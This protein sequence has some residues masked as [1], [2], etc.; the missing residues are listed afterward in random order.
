M[1]KMKVLFVCSGNARFGITPN[2]KNQGES[3]RNNGVQLDY[4]PIKGKGIKGY[5]KNIPKLRNHLKSNKYDLIHAHYGFCGIVSQFARNKEKLI[6]TFMGDDLLGSNKSDGSYT[7]ISKVITN[8]NKYYARYKLDLSI[9]QSKSMQRVLIRRT[10]YCCIPNGVDF[11]VFYPLDQ[12]HSREKLNINRDDKIILFVSDPKRKE[13]NVSLAK[14]A[15]KLINSCR[16]KL[17]VVYSISHKRLNW[18]Y[19]SANLLLL[20]SFHEGSPNVIKEAMACNL[21]IVTTDVGDVKEVIGN[22]KGCFI[23]SYRPEDVAEKVQ[24][25]IDFGKRTNGRENIR[26]LEINVI[27]KKIINIYQD[28][29]KL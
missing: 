11:K 21:P 20:T 5:T 18:F 8:I 26:H 29:F 1:T 28:V 23:A 9:I 22:T 16:K 24:L 15:V 7:K 17:K 10:K 12:Y 4:F 25:A 19:N 13:K 6:L 14:E 3:L 2:V 27:A